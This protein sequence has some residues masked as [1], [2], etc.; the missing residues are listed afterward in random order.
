MK[1]VNLRKGA[2]KHCLL[3]GEC[4]S[5]YDI[6]DGICENCRKEITMKKACG[7]YDSY[8]KMLKDNK[9]ILKDIPP[10]VLVEIVL[11]YAKESE[12]LEGK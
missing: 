6:K 10:E 2:W 8:N 7:Y 4:V 9:I 5:G 11:R 12:F 3:C 1:E